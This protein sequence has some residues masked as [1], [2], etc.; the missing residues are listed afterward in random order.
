MQPTTTTLGLREGLEYLVTLGKG[1]QVVKRF[2]GI[3][4]TNL[5]LTPVLP[6]APEALEFSTLG[7]FAEFANLANQD[8]AREELIVHIAS[9][10]RVALLGDLHNAS[11]QRECYAQAIYDL[12]QIFEFGKYMGAEDFIIR[13]QQAFDP[14]ENSRHDILALVGNM[15]AERVVQAT[16][17]GVSQKVGQKVGVALQGDGAPIRNPYHL[18]CHRTF[19]EAVQ[20]VSPFILRVKQAGDGQV[21]MAALFESDNGAWKYRAMESIKNFLAG[22][23]KDIPILA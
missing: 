14:V 23:I 12:D 16:D 15:T 13:V 11:R 3:D 4:Y 18:A 20:P 9:P 1:D 17:D 19:A 10:F 7:S 5:D 2:H 8:F 6:P 22:E 21:P